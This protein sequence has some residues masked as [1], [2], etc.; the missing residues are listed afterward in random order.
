MQGPG[1][2]A[3]V[4]A[5]LIWGLF[6]LYWSLLGD[7]PTVQVLAHRA[8]WCAACVWLYL[9][10]TAQGRWWRG[11][12]PRVVLTL[13]VTA[14]LISVNWGL[15][16]YGVNSGHVVETSLGYFINPLVN[17]LLGVVVLRE[18]LGAWQWVAVALAALGVGYL[19]LELG[20]VPWIALTLAMSF[21]LYGLLRKLTPVDAVRGLAL[22]STLV[23]PIAI[24]YLLFCEWRG[25]GAFAHGSTGRDLLLI[26][27]GAVTAVPLVLFAYGARRVSLS[28]LGLL[29]YVA[30]TAQLL[31]GVFAF[32]ETFAA[33]QF[34][35]FGCIW[36]A[37]LLAMVD[38]LRR[39][40]ARPAVQP[41]V[42]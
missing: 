3:A 35:A 10:V 26:A 39:W 28:S 33:P 24:A 7:V 40:L 4:G 6:P 5:Y 14:T 2:F 22:E 8:V 21:G 1:A 12:P 41:S 18:R 13:A 34:L 23:L 31:L 36:L 30:P 25:I 15:Y 42:R 32:H 9:A 19:T 38:N 20:A 11:V 27:G 37:L 29:Q 17:V 16:I